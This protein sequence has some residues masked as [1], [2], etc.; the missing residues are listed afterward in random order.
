MMHMEGRSQRDRWRCVASLNFGARIVQKMQLTAL[1]AAATICA[2]EAID[3]GLGLTPPMGWRSWNAYNSRV[4]QDLMVSQ[5]GGLTDRSRTVD[6]KPM[7]LADLGYNNI[8]LDDA[9]QA[10]GAGADGDYHTALGV[11]LVNATRFP[12]MLAMTNHA[13]SLGLSSGW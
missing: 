10:C 12:D 2:V 3:N 1:I 11:P 9:W 5:M 6:G 4:N 13:T 8:G 7:S